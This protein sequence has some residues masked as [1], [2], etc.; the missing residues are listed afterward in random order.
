[1]FISFLMA[2][3][4]VSSHT[5]KRLYPLFFCFLKSIY[6]S[7][8][9]FL[10][11][12]ANI[13]SHTPKHLNP[14]W[15]LEGDWELERKRDVWE[16]E[17][18]RR[19]EERDRRKRRKKEKKHPQRTPGSQTPFLFRG[20]ETACAQKVQWLVVDFNAYREWQIKKIRERDAT[21][22]Q[23]RSQTHF[24][25][26]KQPAC[27]LR[28]QWLVV[29]FNAHKETKRRNRVFREKEREAP[30]IHHQQHRFVIFASYWSGCFRHCGVEWLF[31][32]GSGV[33]GQYQGFIMIST[34]MLPSFTG[35]L[36]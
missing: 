14:V 18:E 32:S 29:G 15:K 10:M 33:W 11:T 7:L 6:E 3:A 2:S 22:V 30:S 34:N 1:M 17:S 28:V 4:N 13:S 31:P 23:F 25:E 20:K 21:S 16:R 36:E 24:S 12:S 9:Q 19:Y 5:P 8:E 27:A 35:T 26:E